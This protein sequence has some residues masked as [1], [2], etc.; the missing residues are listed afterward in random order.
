MFAMASAARACAEALDAGESPG[1]H[2]ARA[3]RRIRRDNWL[4]QRMI[5]HAP[6]H[7]LD[8]IARLAPTLF[9]RQF[10]P[11]WLAPADRPAPSRRD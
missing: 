4:T 2:V 9:V 1:R 3:L 5:T 11:G 8:A 7:L 6:I 10:G